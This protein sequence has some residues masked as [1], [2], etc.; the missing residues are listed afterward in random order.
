M[1][2]VGGKECRAVVRTVGVKS[3]VCAPT[4]SS[5]P[6]VRFPWTMKAGH[7]MQALLS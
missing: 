6:T 3:E 1:D 4:G 7:S 5:E 2:V